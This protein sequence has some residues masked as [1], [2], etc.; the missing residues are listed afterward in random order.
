MKRVHFC[1]QK[2]TKVLT[3]CN[4]YMSMQKYTKV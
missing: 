4:E 3:E 1:I 2:Y